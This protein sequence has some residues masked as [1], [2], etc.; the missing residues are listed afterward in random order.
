MLYDV[1]VS[2]VS[3]QLV[4]KVLRRGRGSLMCSRTISL[5]G[6]RTVM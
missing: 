3:D 2:V 5:S 1:A 4:T 6:N